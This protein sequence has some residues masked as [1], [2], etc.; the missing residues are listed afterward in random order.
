[1]GK[2]FAYTIVAFGFALAMGSALETETTSH[3]HLHGTFLALGMVP[4]IVYFV[5]TETLSAVTLTI[6]GGLLLGADLILRLGAGLGMASGGD[7]TSAIWLMLILTLVVFPAGVL[8][9]RMLSPE[10]NSED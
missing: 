1:M 8:L 10:K 9:G 6:T 4:Y 5:F 7:L 3:H 2:P